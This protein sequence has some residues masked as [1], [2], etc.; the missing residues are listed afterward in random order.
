MVTI[1]YIGTSAKIQWPISD[2]G[3][4]EDDQ[5]KVFSVPAKDNIIGLKKTNTNMVEFLPISEI[6][7]PNSG[8]YLDFIEFEVFDIDDIDDDNDDTDMDRWGASDKLKYLADI[9]SENHFGCIQKTPFK[10]RSKSNWTVRVNRLKRNK[11][12]QKIFENFIL[13]GNLD[14]GDWMRETK[15]NISSSSQTD[16]FRAIKRSTHVLNGEQDVHTKSGSELREMS[17]LRKANVI[18]L[19]ASGCGKSSL[20]NTIRGLGSYEENSA[21]IGV[22]T[23][24]TRVHQAYSWSIHPHVTFIDSPGYNK[25]ETMGRHFEKIQDYLSKE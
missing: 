19:G 8:D 24:G 20:I 25:L 11:L 12:R 17:R 6:E 4:V 7:N 1:G 13:N 21:P 15:F 2:F 18:I 10:Q 16:G 5:R 22:A 9:F 23:R 3:R 14:F